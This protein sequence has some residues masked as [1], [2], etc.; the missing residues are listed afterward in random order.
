MFGA[1]SRVI[2]LLWKRLRLENFNRAEVIVR[3]SVPF[4]IAMILPKRSF[5]YLSELYKVHPMKG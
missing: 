4:M 2:S 1:M 3:T 5:F